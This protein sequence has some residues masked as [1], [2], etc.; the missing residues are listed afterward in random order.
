MTAI[1]RL[2]LLS[3]NSSNSRKRT[4][5]D[6]VLIWNLLTKAAGS[7]RIS[8]SLWWRLALL[9]LLCGAASPAWAQSCTTTGT[10]PKYVY[11]SANNGTY[12]WTVPSDWNSSNNTIEAYGGGGGGA[13]AGAGGGGAYSAITNGSLTPGATI[14]LNSGIAGSVAPSDGADSWLCNSTSNCSSITGSA[15][16]VG[17]KGGVRGAS[18]GLGGA[19]SSG[20]GSTKFSGGN[21]GVGSFIG[22]G[23]GGAGGVNGNGKDGGTGSSSAAG[24]GGGGSGGGTVGSSTSS[25]SVGADGGNN[26]AGSGHGT[27]GNNA[28]GGAGSNGGGGGGGGNFGHNG[29]QGGA[30][31]D[32]VDNGAHGAGG[33]GA[34][35]PG[36]CCGTNAAG[37]AGGILMTYVPAGGSVPQLMLFG[38]GQ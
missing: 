9:A 12:N 34:G 32:G 11:C 5:S 4:R 3:G 38:V 17:A 28:N 19:A 6:Q 15:V 18:T 22:A 10:S 31:T 2:L 13:N 16:I 23:G 36:G 35:T 26:F 27:G 7:L 30:G 25:S 1:S 24:G 20:V 37:A 14:T 21:G 8:T 29:G 33:G